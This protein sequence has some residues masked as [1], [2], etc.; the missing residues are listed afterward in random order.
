MKRVVRCGAWA[1]VALVLW[2]IACEAMEVEVGVGSLFVFFVVALAACF[3]IDFVERRTADTR[4]ICAVVAAAVTI[5]LWA[6]VETTELEVEP[7]V[8]L[9]TFVA[10]FAAYFLALRRRERRVRRGCRSHK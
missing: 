2:W 10:N 7:G 9:V 6:G 4:M 8:Y 1:I 3:A 5:I